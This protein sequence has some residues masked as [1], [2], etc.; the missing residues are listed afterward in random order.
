MNQFSK[1]NGDINIKDVLS[2]SLF[3]LESQAEIVFVM[4]KGGS[5]TW[6]FNSKNEMYRSLSRLALEG[7]QL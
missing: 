1:S 3:P 5:H 2:I 7:L 6:F 4:R